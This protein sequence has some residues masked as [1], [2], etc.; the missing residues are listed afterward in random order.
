MGDA[1]FDRSPAFR[2]MTELPADEVFT[3]RTAELA[4]LA[5]ILAPAG[6][7]VATVA[8]P[9][10]V[11]KTALVLRAARESIDSFP[12]GVLFVDL[13]APDPL[14]TLLREL[15]V[16]PGEQADREEL[17]RSTLAATDLPVLVI[18]DNAVTPERVLPLR[19]GTS[20]H[21][22]VVISRD[23]VPILDARRIQLDVLSTDAAITVVATALA[24]TDPD[25]TRIAAEP[26]AAAQ[27]V[28]LCGCRPLALRIAAE[29]LAGQPTRSLAELV[30]ALTQDHDRMTELADG[31]SIAVRLAFDAAYQNLTTD[32]ARLFGLLPLNPGPF[33]DHDAAGALAGVATDVARR[34]LDGLR[35]AQLVERSP[36]AAGYHLHD[37]LTLYADERRVDD[38]GAVERLLD[39]YARATAEAAAAVDGQPGRFTDRATALAWL[40]AQRPNLVAAVELAVQVGADEV[41]ADLV[42]ALQAYFDLRGYWT[43]WIEATERALAPHREAGNQHAELLTLI[44]LS[45]GHAVLGH[46]EQAHQWHAAALAVI[47]ELDD[48][49]VAARALMRLGESASA[50]GRPADAEAALS[51]AVTRWQDVGDQFR[52][53]QALLNLGIVYWQ[54]DK[55]VEAEETQRRALVINEEIDNAYGVAT[56]FSY[57]GLIHRDL[58][59]WNTAAAYYQRSIT[60]F[61]ELREPAAV[62]NLES[63]MADLIRRRAAG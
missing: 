59:D 13:H 35:R 48:G 17:Y 51:T 61:R 12:G 40:D 56:T 15:G 47:E 14:A 32:Q 62:A 34:Q 10:G 9:A 26:D 37:L 4:T 5:E 11:G 18:A 29:L 7:A 55:L 50:Y 27:L 52:E 63:L 22:L 24:V 43:E 20:V 60:G 53:G 23:A 2:A 54:T 58:A 36:G 41:A 16:A 21:R 46:D 49:E 38:D 45:L 57:L 39:H 33:V 44:H 3:G 28:G 1:H 8:G 25:D 42:T 19:L 31:D 30:A 6:S